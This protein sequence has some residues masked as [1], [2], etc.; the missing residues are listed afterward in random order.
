[1]STFTCRHPNM[2][3]LEDIVHINRVSLPENYPIGYFIQLIK[4]WK[5]TSAIAEMDGNVVGYVLTRIEKFS[6]SGFL[7][8]RYP[9]SHVISVA[10]LPEVRGLGIG[11]ELMKFV[12]EKVTQDESIKEMTLEVRKSNTPAILMYEKLNFSKSKILDNYY[13]DGEEAL[14][15]V[16]KFS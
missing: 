7:S 10:V 13:R 3:D 14:V 4:D 2:G 6:F 9:K 15:M 1:M 12:I 16:L 8:G 5:E 11:S